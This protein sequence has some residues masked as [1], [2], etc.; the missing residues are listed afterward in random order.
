M[1]LSQWSRNFIGRTIINC[2]TGIII[3]FFNNIIK[4]ILK[5]FFCHNEPPLIVYS[6]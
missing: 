3:K 5:G 2:N 4:S 6:A 1:S